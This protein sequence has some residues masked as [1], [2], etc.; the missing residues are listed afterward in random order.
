ML[1][2]TPS[3]LLTSIDDKNLDDGYLVAYCINLM[4]AAIKRRGELHYKPEDAMALLQMCNIVV[5]A[6]RRVG[7]RA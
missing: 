4:N 1:D 3:E 5:E 7:D 2:R 6:S